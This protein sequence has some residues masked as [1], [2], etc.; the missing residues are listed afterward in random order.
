M[1]A[2][3]RYRLD[4]FDQALPATVL[5]RL[6]AAHAADV[7]AAQRTDAV[8]A[9]GQQVAALQAITR[10]LITRLPAS[11]SWQVL[12]A[13]IV[14]VV[15]ASASRPASRPVATE[16]VQVSAASLPQGLRRAAGFGRGLEQDHHSLHAGAAEDRALHRELPR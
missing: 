16:K 4:E 9:W 6:S 7:Y 13:L 15:V 8:I 14:R 12:I 3:A 1:P 10:G 5:G 11:S 2:Y